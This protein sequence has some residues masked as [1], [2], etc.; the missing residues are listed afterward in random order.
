MI[1]LLMKKLIS[2][3]AKLLKHI[4]PLMFVGIFCGSLY[5]QQLKQTVRGTVVDKVSQTPIIGA[6]IVVLNSSP[7]IGA[8]TDANGMFILKN[9][10][11]GRQTIKVTYMGYK[12]ATLSN[13]VINSG[14]EVVLNINIE[15]EIIEA[16][17]AVVK[18]NIIKTKPLNDMATV[19]TRTFSVE[20]T[21]KFAAAVNDP[22]R[23]ATSFAG[24]VGGHDGNNMISIRGNSPNALLWR[25]EGVEIPNPNHFSSVGT[26][27][28]GISIL[29]A[30]LLANSDFMTG[31]F[32]AE[33]GNALGGVFDLKLRKGNN[34]KREYTFQAGVLGVDFATEGPIKKGYDGSYLINYR[35]STLSLLELMGLNLTGDA[36]TNFQDLAF[37]VSLPSKKMG[38]FGVYGMG[39]LSTQTAQ[40]KKDTTTWIED[41]FKQFEVDFKANTGVFGVNNTKL[42][43]SK[44][45]LKSA[46]VFSGTDNSVTEQ[47]L[48]TLY[49]NRL[50]YDQSYKQTKL[51]LTSTLTHK[52]DAKNSLRTGFICNILG[53]NFTQKQFID[54]LAILQTL[55]NN[56]GNTQTMQAYAQWQHKLNNRLSTNIGLHTLHLALNNSYSIEP[57]TSIKYDVT[58]GSYIALGYGLHGQIQPLGTYFAQNN[59]SLINKNIG[60]SKAHHYVLTYDFSVTTNTHIK[61]EAYYQDLFNIPVSKD[62][63]KNFSL[64]NSVEGFT[65][66]PLANNGKARNYGL[67]I[68]AERFLHKNF[69]YLLSASL[70]QSEYKTQTNVWHNTMFNTNFATTFTGG[71]EWNLKNKN[72][73]LGVNT[74]L[75]YVGGMRYTPIDE[76]ASVAKGRVVYDE[77]KP[78]SI[79][80]PN[81]FRVDFRV[82]LKR[83]YTRLTSTVSLDLQNAT[84]RANVGGQYYDENAQKVKY[85]YQTGLIPVLAYK[86]EF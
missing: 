8:A 34:Q 6:T 54:S 73:V 61:L 79:K 44:S 51:T 35:Y 22:A 85:W 1:Y 62:L 32:A 75:V 15:E 43:R 69:Y 84:N 37:N 47:K 20:E 10:S 33:Y 80:N 17:E 50:N 12:A 23:M 4:L 48:N 64:V 27:G 13:L 68:T 31:A 46:I 76:V 11:V 74:K 18:A 55:I 60:I 77:L 3:G 28:G 9:V 42:I 86:I 65:T 36:T 72:R 41:P 45:V 26:S 52:V 56:N 59:G 2:T 70:Y 53:Y 40:S 25:M 78:F 83:N 16:K 29:S 81:Y 38:T 58:A 82:S 39:G 30:Q 57:R 7:V 67:E 5:A 14:K 19:S 63:S 49:Q 66:M 24:V 71:K 21:Q